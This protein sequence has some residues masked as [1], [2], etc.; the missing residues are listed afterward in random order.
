MTETMTIDFD[1]DMPCKTP[2]A[3]NFLGI[4][5]ASMIQRR[6]RGQPPEFLKIGRAVRYLPSKLARYRDECQVKPEAAEA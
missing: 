6:R 3:A 2:A 4:T 1:T 5:E